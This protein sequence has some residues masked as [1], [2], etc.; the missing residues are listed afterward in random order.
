[1]LFDIYM[2]EAL[3]TKQ[4]FKEIITDAM[5]KPVNFLKAQW[6]A[7]KKEFDQYEPELCSLI[8]KKFGMDIK[9]FADIDNAELAINQSQMITED[10]MY[11]EN[12]QDLWNTIKTE[13]QAAL[14]FWPIMQL[15]LEFDKF[16]RDKEVSSKTVFAY[17]TFWAALVIG[18]YLKGRY[19]KKIADQK[20]EERRARLKKKI[21]PKIMR[22]IK[23]TE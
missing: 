12:I 9:S 10:I 19:D 21:K 3:D 5:H 13:A 7:Y 2:E 1:M 17:G 22:S 16:I 14:F 18:K 11:N 4:S 23:K 20:K 6:A 8:S 15:W